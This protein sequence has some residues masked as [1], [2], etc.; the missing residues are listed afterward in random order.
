MTRPKDSPVKAPDPA[1]KDA[2][3]NEFTDIAIRYNNGYT[4]LVECL[5]KST[6]DHESAERVANYYLK[7][8]IAKIQIGI[9]QFTVKHGAFLDADV[10]ANAV[11]ETS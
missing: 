3:M 4:R 9:G 1:Q 11:A 2:S 7:H 6:P 5:A 8:K 10:I